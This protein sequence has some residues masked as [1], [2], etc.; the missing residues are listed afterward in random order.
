[1][2]LPLRMKTWN[3]FQVTASGDLEA[4]PDRKTCQ[5]QE[6]RHGEELVKNEVVLLELRVRVRDEMFLIN[7]GK[8]K[9]KDKESHCNLHR[10]RM[11]A[12][13]RTTPNRLVDHTCQ[14]LPQ[15]SGTFSAPG[16][17]LA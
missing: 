1:M 5:G 6:T 4:F 13:T 2:G 3:Y 16:C 15:V 7:K 8:D 10:V 14:L 11:F 17:A 9:D 12:P